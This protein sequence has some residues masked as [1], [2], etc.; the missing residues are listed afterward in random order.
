MGKEPEEI[1]LT[2]MN[3]PGRRLRWT[4]RKGPTEAEGGGEGED[5]WAG[6]PRSRR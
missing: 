1:K 2:L 4:T 5:V 6:L 3:G